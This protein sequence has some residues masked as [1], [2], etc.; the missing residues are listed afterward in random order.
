VAIDTPNHLAFYLFV[1][2]Q[3]AYP[4]SIMGLFATESGSDD[5]PVLI[6]LQVWR[7]GVKT[8]SK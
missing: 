5:A 7:G 4:A 2:Q 8:C 3:L 1:L 6:K